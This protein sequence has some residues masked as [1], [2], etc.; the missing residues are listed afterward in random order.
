M[1]TEVP[2]GSYAQTHMREF[3]QTIRS[4]HL[5]EF[6]QTLQRMMPYLPQ[7]GMFEVDLILDANVVI[8]ELLWLACKREKPDARTGLMEVMDCKVVRAYA[9]H[10]LKREIAENLPEVAAKQGID[11]AVLQSLWGAYRSKIIFVAVG[12]PPRSGKW[13]DPK[14]VPYLRLQRRLA[15]PIVSADPH[16]EAMGAKVVRV[17]I[18]GTLRGYSRAAAVEY[19]LKASG[20]FSAALAATLAEGLFSTIKRLPAPVLWGGAILSILLLVHPKSRA[21]ILEIGEALVEG[22]ARAIPEISKALDPVLTAHAKARDDAQ[23]LL[24]AAENQLRV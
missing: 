24:S 17:Q 10:F 20:A 23:R 8:S 15:C 19:Q 16:L 13:R 3:I 6:A 7:I 18:F 11:L 1:S 2:A 14:D 5:P 12:G 4:D 9:P 22:G 21:K